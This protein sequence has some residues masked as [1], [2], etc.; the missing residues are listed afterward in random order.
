MLF[1]QLIELSQKVFSCQHPAPRDRVGAALPEAAQAAAAHQR[2]PHFPTWSSSKTPTLRL[3]PDTDRA[4]WG[5]ASAWAGC[6]GV[7][8]SHVLAYGAG[9]F[10]WGSP[11]G[12][13]T[14]PEAGGQLTASTLKT[15]MTKSLPQL[16]WLGIDALSLPNV[17]QY[18]NRHNPKCGSKQLSSL[19]HHFWCLIVKHSACLLWQDFSIQDGLW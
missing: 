2:V 3:P 17:K 14:V 11:V 18:C 9:G 6:A 12:T 13:Q 15:T 16:S 8:S 4:A 10:V 7:C 19:D 1:S 5:T